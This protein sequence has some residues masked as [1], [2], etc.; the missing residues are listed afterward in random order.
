MET[1][2]LNKRVLE[3]PMGLYVD[4]QE[5]MASDSIGPLLGKQGKIAANRLKSN[6]NDSC[7]SPTRLSTVFHDKIS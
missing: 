1:V 7:L 6:N 3:A 4:Q 5:S 2:A